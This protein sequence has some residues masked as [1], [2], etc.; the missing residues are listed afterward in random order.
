MLKIPKIATPPFCPSEVQGSITFDETAGF[1]SKLFRFAG[2]GFLV[3]VG[4]IDPGN[5]ATDIEAGS[6]FGYDL[7]FV[8]VFSSLAAMLLQS[9]SMRLGIVTGKDLAQNTRARNNKVSSVFLWLMAELSIIACDLAEVLGG[10]L[11]FHL[12]L[13][14]PLIV[15]IFLTIL[16]T[17]I[18]L[19]LQGRNFR[20]LEAII[21]G[22]VLTVGVS[23][24]IELFFIKP[25]WPDVFNGLLPT[26]Q[27]LMQ[28]FALPLAVGIIGATVMPHNLYLH[29]SVIQTRIVRKDKKSKQQ[30]IR[31]S[32]FDT[33]IS[34]FFAMLI[35]CAILMLAAGAFHTQG[36]VVADIGDAYH[37]LNPLVGSAL[38]APLFG[39][40]LLA[41]GQSSTFTGT[42]A[43]Q[44][45]ME[46]FVDL[47]IPCWQ[48]RLITR[49]LALIPALLGV[50]L[51]GE[52]SLGKMLVLSQIVLSL[53]LPFAMYPLIRQTSD[54]KLMGKFTIRPLTRTIA[55]AIFAVIA[56][57]NL[58]MM[59]GLF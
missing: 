37:L 2:P 12:L 31:F 9:L 34:L 53:Q 5:W 55:Y 18:V 7:L 25:F 47:K 39:L 24:G 35:N 43:G 3:A 36:H 23:F 14:V 49:C 26:T 10:A 38:A 58:W 16:D 54:L 40:A 8:V 32:A 48:R 42:I 44:V 17:V 41:S 28:P 6:R 46:G 33:V 45:I 20:T 19:G 30:A 13:G 4:Y 21:L 51:W 11:A 1:W 22:L 27:K 57:C 15:G 59:K 56:G 29:S 50:W 52:G